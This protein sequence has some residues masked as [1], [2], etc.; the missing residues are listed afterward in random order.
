MARKTFHKKQT[1]IPR[2]YDDTFIDRKDWLE[3]HGRKESDV[4]QDAVG[5]EYIMVDG[6]EG[7]EKVDVPLELRMEEIEVD[8]THD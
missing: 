1:P 3:E 6:E 7:Y 5:D 8:T 4:M 2:S